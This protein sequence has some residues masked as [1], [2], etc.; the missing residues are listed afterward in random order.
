MTTLV[1]IRDGYLYTDWYPLLQN[2]QMSRLKW[3]FCPRHCGVRCN[4][5]ADKWTGLV[6]VL[7]VLTLDAPTVLAVVRDNLAM[8]REEESHTKDILVSQGVSRARG[9]R[10][11]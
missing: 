2:S 10:A 11:T 5:I 8:A 4:K 7:E 3:I 6:D 9:R 1:K